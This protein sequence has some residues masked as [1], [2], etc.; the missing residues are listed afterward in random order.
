MSVNIYTV[1]SITN[2]GTIDNKYEVQI[3]NGT[4]DVT[5]NYII[6]YIYGSLTIEVFNATV[7]TGSGEKVYDGQILANVIKNIYN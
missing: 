7:V 5:D 4:K 2:V 1:S 3:F 6:N